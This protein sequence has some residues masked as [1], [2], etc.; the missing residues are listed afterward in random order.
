VL[1]LAYAPGALAQEPAEDAPL[2]EPAALVLQSAQVLLEPS[3]E[4]V[5]VVGGCWLSTHT[6]IASAQRLAAAEAQVEV[7]GKP[8]STEDFP[9]QVIVVS[10]LVGA[11]L[12]AAT[13]VAAHRLSK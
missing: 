3:G 7:L 10:L 2:V 4:P 12:G 5:A 8:L 9:T 13:A 1:L 6:C 11:A